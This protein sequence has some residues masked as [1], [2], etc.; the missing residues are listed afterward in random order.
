MNNAILSAAL[1]RLAIGAALILL[2]A[3]LI[4]APSNL[5]ALLVCGA[6]DVLILWGFWEAGRNS[7]N[8]PATPVDPG[9]PV[10][11]PPGPVQPPA[12]V[13][14][15]AAKPRF[16][17]ITAT[18]FGGA[19]DTNAS[20]YGGMVAPGSPGVALPYRFTGTRP[21]VRVFYN[22]R[23][24]DCDICDIGP[25]NTNDPYWQSGARP[26]AESGTDKSGR[27]TNLAG[28][29]LTPAAW[30]ALGYPMPNSAKAKV[31]WDFVDQLAAPAPT[32]AP[33]PIAPGGTPPQLATIRSL[34]AQ[35]VHAQ[36]DSAVIMAWPGAIAAKF[37]DMADYCKGY[38]HDSIPWCGL[39]MA[40]CMAMAGIRPPFDPANDT[41]SFLWAFAWQTWGTD[42][43]DNPQPGDICVFRWSGGG[44]HVTMYDHEVDDDYYHCSGGNQ[45][46]G[47]VCSTEAMPMGNCIAIR[48]PPAS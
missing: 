33:A 41:S 28:I 40:Y 44:G 35:G 7:V 37:P 21:K 3:G 45:G 38:V 1:F 32:P 6:V 9:K 25:W 18:S 5:I 29:D 27:T 17:G 8:A 16:T 39:T 34:I 30:T 23:T 46:S 12:P 36:H 15:A 2:G 10:P 19:G 14:P 11:Q 13:Q 31:D 22:G 43:T 24:V 42:A 26:Q 4:P 20:A 47:H 48:R